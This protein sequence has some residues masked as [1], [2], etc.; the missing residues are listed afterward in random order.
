MLYGCFFS[1]LIFSISS[2]PSSSQSSKHNVREGIG[3]KMENI[4]SL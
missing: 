1:F 3:N 4:M 2:I